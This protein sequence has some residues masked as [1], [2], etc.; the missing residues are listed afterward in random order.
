MANS[1]DFFINADPTEALGR[2]ATV[3]EREGFRITQNQDGSLNAERGKMSTTIWLGALAGKSFHV[4]L[5]AEVFTGPQG[6]AVVRLH[7]NVGKAALKG[8]AI[9]AAKGNR[10]YEETA[11]AVHTD[12]ASSGHLTNSVA[13]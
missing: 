4:M 6:G 7:R 8:G 2:V 3:L 5:R 13:N 12:L 9:G 1:H 10:V 11:N